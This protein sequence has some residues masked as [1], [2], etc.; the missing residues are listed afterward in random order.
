MAA[1]FPGVLLAAL[2]ALSAAGCTLAYKTDILR[3]DVLTD[4]QEA[5]ANAKLSQ[6]AMTITASVDRADTTYDLGQPI[7]LT[8]S[9][10]KDAFIAILRVLPNGDTA[11]VFPNRAQ[12]IAYTPAGTK[13]VV[14]GPD[15]AVKIAA[16]K[17]GVV[18]FEVIASTIGHSWLFSRAPDEGSDFADLGVSSR[19]IANDVITNVKAGVTHDIAATPLTVR[20]AGRGLF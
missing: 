10:S 1:R 13:V 3:K 15:D 6:G 16:D 20:I 2:V 8:V 9:A 17:P 12:R 11:I 14:P 4:A 18:L 7:T 5:I 19:N